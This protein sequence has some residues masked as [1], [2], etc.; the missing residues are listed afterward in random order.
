MSWTATVAPVFRADASAP[1]AVPWLHVV[2]AVW[3]AGG[4]VMAAA[5]L[6]G[7]RRLARL[8]ARCT[9]VTTG[10]WRELTDELAVA[11]GVRRRVA[12]LQSDDPSLL[13]T[14]GVLRPR[15]I[16]PSGAA[17]WTDDRRRSVLRHELAHIRRHDAAVQLAAEALRVLQWI[18]PLVWVACRRLRQ[19]SE[20]A[21]DD[22][23]LR[24][25]VDATDYATHLLD[26]ARHL[27]RR[28]VV[29]ASA[30]AIADPSTLERRIVAMLHRQNNRA[31]LGRR[32]WGVALAALGLTIPLAAVGS[33]SAVEPTVAIEPAAD[34]VLPTVPPAHE[35][36]A[37]RRATSKPQTA[38]GSI[39]GTILDQSGGTLP[40]VFVTITNVA[41]GAQ[42]TTRT[43]A[44]GRFTAGQLP[45]ADYELTAQLP[46]FATLVQRVTLAAGATVSGTLT[47]PVGRLQETITVACAASVSA[48]VRV[49][50]ATIANGIVPRLAA[51]E[52]AQPIRV[53]GNLR[54]PRK[55]LDVRPVCPATP[56]VSDTVVTITATIGV[57][58]TVT[59][60]EPA[61]GTDS[62]AEVVDAAV[63]AI[64]QWKFTPT[65][66]NGSPVEVEMTVRVTF[67]R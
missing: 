56:P 51:Q 17:S 38:P 16:L 24:G 18:N 60:L 57:D 10:A 21:C 11:C 63:T 20:Y 7:I 43:N 32:G 55:I 4:M 33:G 41:S 59:D 8:E 49:I 14:C 2:V 42:V 65:L 12:V 45:A 54:A 47:L 25:G 34:V 40:G 36:V 44:S 3:A 46:G 27:S 58:G 64:R 66:L 28:R 62:P 35:P 61:P 9:P 19:E 15:I 67:T 23:V 1:T 50:I 29:R 5:L 39:A 53:G 52:P 31:P 30:P 37:A 13:I 6:L 22:A 26:I 48:R